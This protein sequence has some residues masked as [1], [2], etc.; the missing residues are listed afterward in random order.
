MIKNKSNGILI[1]LGICLSICLISCNSKK[2]ALEIQNESI[3]TQDNQKWI[4]ALIKAYRSFNEAPNIES[5]DLLF[6]ASE[7]MPKK[8]WENY[9]MVATVYA[10]NKKNDKAFDALEKALEAG[11]K[12]SELLNS[13]PP[14][15]SLHNDS[16]WETL[17]SKAINKR[18]AY[19]KTIENRALLEALEKMWMLDQQ[20]LSEYEQN[21]KLLDS[22][23]TTEDYSRLFKPVENRWEIN[24]Q[25]LDSIINIHGWPGYKLVGEEG[26]KISWAIP[27]HHPDV[28]FKNKCLSLIKKSLEKGDTD[29]NHYAELHD[30]IARETWQKQIFGASMRNDAPYPIEDPVN[31]NKRRLELG[32]PEPIEIYA[33]YHGI[34]YK[35]PNA[36]ESKTE[37]KLAYKNAQNHYTKFEEFAKKKN[38]DSANVYISKG[39]SFY[40]DISNKQLY[41]AVIELAQMNNKRSEHI[42]LRILKVLIWRKWNGRHEILTQSEFN[43]L[44]SKQEWVKIEELLKMSK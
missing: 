41:K 44:Q 33:Y 37:L 16:R 15:F 21:L 2:K 32:L 29:P 43:S 24:K 11:L 38:I 25:K 35:V 27:Q 10:P 8:N 40:G 36:E 28:F 30:R 19:L 14:L 26:A 18:K 42:T 39:I 34:E 12:D 20:A 13:L 9:L 5:A 6:E 3:T 22:T 7:L 31:V 4:G 23:A 1:L 17:V